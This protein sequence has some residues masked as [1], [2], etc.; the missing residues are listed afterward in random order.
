MALSLASIDAESNKEKIKEYNNKP[1]ELEFQA[2]K[3]SFPPSFATDLESRLRQIGAFDA[4][5]LNNGCVNDHIIKSCF[6]AD[7]FS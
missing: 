5:S 1:K 4:N 7:I 6:Q 3:S 2:S